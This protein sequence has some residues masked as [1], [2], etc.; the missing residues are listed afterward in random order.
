[1]QTL[2]N[3]QTVKFAI[4]TNVTT[5]AARPRPAS[6]PAAARPA[7]LKRFVAALVNSMSTWAA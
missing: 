3:R 4:P 6:A 7:I 1:M 2:I 5:G